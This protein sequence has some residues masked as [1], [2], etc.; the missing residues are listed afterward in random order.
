M[1]FLF[2]V[3]GVFD[4]EVQFVAIG[5]RRHGETISQK[6]VKVASF[7][8]RLP[9]HAVSL[10]YFGR[11]VLENVD[12]AI[13]LRVRI[14]AVAPKRAPPVRAGRLNEVATRSLGYAA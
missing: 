4:V 12:L 13:L 6:V 2:V 5:K 14:E 1:M 7:D 8:G 9:P 10:P 11:R 3:P